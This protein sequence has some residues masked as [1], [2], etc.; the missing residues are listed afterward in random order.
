M[1]ARHASIRRRLTLYVLAVSAGTLLLTRALFFMFD[2]QR[3]QRSA[4]GQLSTLG[5]ITAANGAEL[6]LSGDQRRIQALLDA[7]APQKNVVAACF[8]DLRGHLL[9]AYPEALPK[10]DFPTSPGPAGYGRDGVFVSGFQ[11]VVR[12]GGRVGTLYLK[13]DLSPVLSAWLVES[14]EVSAGILAF[15]LAIAYTTSRWLGRQVSQPILD[16]AGVA[17]TITERQDFSARVRA[18]KWEE[19]GQLAAEFNQMLERIEQ[20]SREIRESE[21]RLRTIVENLNEG[22]VASDLEGQLL[23]FNKAALDLHGF[24]TVEEC[25]L[26]L[27]QFAALIELSTLDGEILGLEDW[28]L[29]RVLRGEELRNFEV[30]FRHLDPPW[31]RIY[32]YGGTLVRNAEGVPIVAILTIEDVTQRKMTELQARELNAELEARVVQRTAQL[33]AANRELEAFSYSVSHDLRAPL[34]HIDGFSALLAQNSQAALDDVGRRYL[35]TISEA[36]KKMGRLIDDL[37]AFSRA[38]RT[39]LKSARVDQDAMVAAIISEGRF[40]SAGR[41][42][43]WRVSPLPAVEADPAMLR[44]VWA[45]LIDNAVKYT[46]K[47]EKPRIEIGFVPGKNGEGDVFFVKDNGVGFEMKYVDKLFGVFQRLHSAAEFDGT[48]IGL[49]NVRRIITRHGGRTWAEGS[50]GIGAAFFFT[51]PRRAPARAQAEPKAVAAAC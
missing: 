4:I 50:V 13:L 23:H 18:A 34:R 1:A 49:A 10:G 7:L 15:I 25:R 16:M 31:S 2:Y 17:R 44:Q 14:I 40:E 28:P 29:A 24:A 22:L 8:Y 11:P 39:E 26:H 21:G 20:Q 47:G 36:A 46:S 6:V 51:L 45:N 30:R 38:G 33:E 5:E 43:E 19:T 32:K 27:A 35:S 9:A 42:I 48:G 12:G 3:V 37:L 41:P